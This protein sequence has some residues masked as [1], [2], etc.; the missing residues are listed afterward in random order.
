MRDGPDSPVF[1]ER[2]AWLVEQVGADRISVNFCGPAGLL[3]I[4][5]A[6]MAHHGVPESRL[7]YEKFE[8][9]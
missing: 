2:F 5:R 6:E 4:V 8:F 7:R 3:A 9:R 1:N